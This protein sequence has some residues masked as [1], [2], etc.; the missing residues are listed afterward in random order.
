MSQ[1]EDSVELAGK[2]G[3]MA[4]ARQRG[5]AVNAL[6]NVGLNLYLANA[7]HDALEEPQRVGAKRARNR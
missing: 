3:V 4:N 7:A 6:S 1:Y 2:A 5:D